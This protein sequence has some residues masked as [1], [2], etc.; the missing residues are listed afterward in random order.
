MNEG[1]NQILKNSFTV[2]DQTESSSIDFIKEK[3]DS[4]LKYFFICGDRNS[5]N[6]HVYTS[7]KGDDDYLFW[8]ISN[9]I[10]AIV[11]DG[12]EDEFISKLRLFIK[13]RYISELCPSNSDTKRDK[14]PGDEC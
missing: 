13:R 14:K 4:G 8:L 7:H 1:E 6:K 2:D 3:I 11:I 9:L 12:K 10:D 5:D